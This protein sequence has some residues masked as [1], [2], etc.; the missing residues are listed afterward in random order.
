MSGAM[1]EKSE[2]FGTLNCN[3]GGILQ[4]ETT[5]H[6]RANLAGEA[7]VTNDTS[8]TFDVS[9]RSVSAMQESYKE[10]M[11]NSYYVARN[12]NMSV[13]VSADQENGSYILA[14]WAGEANKKTYTLTVDGEKVGTFSTTNSLTYN[15]KT[16]SLYC[17]D[18]STNSKALT[19]KVCDAA[20]SASDNSDAWNTLGTGDF[21]GDGVAETLYSNANGVLSWQKDET[22][23]LGT[24]SDTEQIADITDYNNDGFDDLMVYNTATDQMTAWLIKDG[25]AYGALAIA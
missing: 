16:Y 24:L 4:G 1:A 3:N 2:I 23:S 25:T 7:I 22:L 14:N 9:G 8:I 12:A 18:D 19:L 11:L 13:A 17:F 20:K 15:G 21:N 6:G 10:A 5:I